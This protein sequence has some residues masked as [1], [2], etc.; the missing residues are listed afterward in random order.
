M[1]QH[2]EIPIKNPT[3]Q[4][5]DHHTPSSRSSE[6]ITLHKGHFVMVHS[7]SGGRYLKIHTSNQTT[8][9]IFTSLII[10]KNHGLLSFSRS[11][12]T[13]EKTK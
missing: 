8:N 2:I 7:H 3:W 6:G 12:L 5:L 11:L 1:K 4:L 13:A 9:Y 10:M